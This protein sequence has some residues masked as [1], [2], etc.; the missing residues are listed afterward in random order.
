[1]MR[2]LMV[3]ALGLLA[4][5]RADGQT[6]PIVVEMTVT[7]ST[8][9]VG[10]PVTVSL[11]ALDPNRT[12]GLRLIPPSLSEFGQDP[13]DDI[14]AAFEVINGIPSTVY[15]QQITI[16]PHR[17]GTF[18]IEPA[19]AQIPETPLTASQSISSA[20]ATLNVLPLPQ[21][22]PNGFTNAVGD[23][24]VT[25]QIDR[26]SIQPNESIALT[27]SIAG[28]GNLSVIRPPQLSLASDL[29]RALPP[30]RTLASDRRSLAFTWTLLPL[31]S[32]NL[33]VTIPPFAWYDLTKAD[34]RT[35]ESQTM[36]VNVAPGLTSSVPSVIS[37]PSSLA[38]TPASPPLTWA[39]DQF[40]PITPRLWPDSVLVW[41][42]P[43]SLSMIVLGLAAVVKRPVRQ[44]QRRPAAAAPLRADLIRAIQLPPVQAYPLLEQTFSRELQKRQPQGEDAEVWLQSLPAPLRERITSL[45]RDLADARFAPASR[46]DV[47]LHAQTIFR[48]LRQLDTFS[49]RS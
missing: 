13:P 17:S 35:L 40:A 32:G 29:W 25:P 30:Q 41:V 33:T 9:V 19:R 24:V 5:A 46:D 14:V 43:F 22:A 4:V 10:Q 7:P 20:P 37:I 45:Q 12:A 36:V 34:Y 21:P 8:V 28:E 23:L 31:Q 16:Y 39:K 2:A 47:R 18:V 6:S 38:P 48:I 26:T 15:S 3:L 11:R 42:L 49:E 44:R 27:L 1:M